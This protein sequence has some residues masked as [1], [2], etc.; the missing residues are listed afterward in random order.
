MIRA[1]HHSSI[2]T[3]TNSGRRFD[4]CDKRNIRSKLHEECFQCELV[5]FVFVCFV[6]QQKKKI[7]IFSCEMWKMA[8]MSRRRRLWWWL[9]FL[10]IFWW[11]LRWWWWRWHNILSDENRLIV[12]SWRMLSYIYVWLCVWV[13]SGCGVIRRVCKIW[14][15]KTNRKICLSSNDLTISEHP[16]LRIAIRKHRP[17]QC[18]CNF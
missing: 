11:Y 2:Y 15:R 10:L 4:N 16:I 5:T 3:C 18:Y 6:E 1:S 7:L 9:R 14:R 17:E 12:I 13:W 8:R